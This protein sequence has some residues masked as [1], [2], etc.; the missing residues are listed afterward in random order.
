MSSIGA[1]GSPQLF[2]IEWFRRIE[3][4]APGIVRH[5]FERTIPIAEPFQAVRICTQK[6]LRAQG[7]PLN[8]MDKLV[9]MKRLIRR[10]HPFYEIRV[11]VCDSIVIDPLDLG[12]APQA[13]F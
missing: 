4:P 7:A 5:P 8:D 12:K 2:Q 10:P 11:Q 9:E 3:K 6:A 1:S 13:D